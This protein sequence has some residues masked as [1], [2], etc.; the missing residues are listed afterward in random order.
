[1][2][3]KK[4][5]AFRSNV[6]HHLQS[7]FVGGDV[8]IA[9]VYCDYKD[10]ENQT[11]LNLLSSITK[12]FALQCKQL[13]EQVKELYVKH[14]N[15]Q[16]LPS[17]EDYSKLLTILSNGFRRSFILIDALDELPNVEDGRPVFEIDIVKHLYELQ[18]VMT[19]KVGCSLFLT[20]RENV[21][22][23][24]QLDNCRRIDIYAAESDIRLYI[25]SQICDS[26][27]FRYAKDLAR[28]PELGD[29]IISTLVG[30][31]TGM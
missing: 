14:K 29:R 21:Q 16:S 19:S 24:K 8:C 1:M 25:E 26:H 15:G 18:R 22:I 20:S 7:F 31:A 13:P 9:Y 4:L 2:T 28:S 30:K 17:L 23:E 6:V 5:I 3:N 11:T 10:Q 27:K 12:Q